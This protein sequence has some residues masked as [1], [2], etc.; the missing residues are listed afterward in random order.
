VIRPRPKS[1]LLA[2]ACLFAAALCC[3]QSSTRISPN[4]PVLNFRLPY[5]TPEGFRAWLVRG[6][7]AR[8][9]SDDEVDVKDLTLTVFAGDSTERIET[10]LLSPTARIMRNEQVATGDSTLR[11]INDRFEAAGTGWRY[12]HKGKKVSILQNVHVT[13]RSELK[14]LLK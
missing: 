11:V 6:S 7:E 1:L 12:D 5:W 10:I 8:L 2:G 13:F 9:V 14:D 3:A 4:T